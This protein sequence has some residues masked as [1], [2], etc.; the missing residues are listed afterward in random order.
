MHKVCSLDAP[1]ALPSAQAPLLPCLH[2]CPLTALISLLPVKNTF[3]VGDAFPDLILLETLGY[4]HLVLLLCS[5]FAVI[6]QPHL[7]E[8]PLLFPVLWKQDFVS[9]GV[10]LLFPGGPMLG[11]GLDTS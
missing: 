8:E 2:V 11:T 10:G 9:P 1:E 5:L 6:P 3:G 4:H 7:L